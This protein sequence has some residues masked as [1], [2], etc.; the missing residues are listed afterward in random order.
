MNNLLVPVSAKYYAL[1]NLAL[2]GGFNLGV[3]LSAKVKENSETNISG[4][5]EKRT[6]QLTLKKTPT[7]LIFH[8]L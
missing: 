4:S 3:I 6:I 1:N 7:L 5:V 2:S 8:R